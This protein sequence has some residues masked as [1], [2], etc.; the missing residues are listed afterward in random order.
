[1]GHN[2]ISSNW[3]RKGKI[4]QRRADLKM[5]DFREFIY[6]VTQPKSGSTCVEMERKTLQSYEC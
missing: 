5:S 2:D 4:R 3:D 1:M 6:S